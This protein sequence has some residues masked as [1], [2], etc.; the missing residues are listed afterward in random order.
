MGYFQCPRCYG[1]DSFKQR[2]QKF[3]NLG[4]SGVGISNVIQRYCR[5]CSHVKMGYTKTAIDWYLISAAVFFFLTLPLIDTFS[6]SPDAKTLESKNSL[7]TLLNIIGISLAIFFYRVFATLHYPKKMKS[8]FALGKGEPRRIM[9]R[10]KAI[11]ICLLIVVF[12]NL[13]NF[14]SS[15][16]IDTRVKCSIGGVTSYEFG[17]NPKCPAK[18]QKSK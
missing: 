14:G 5:R 1:T 12:F 16:M 9:G 15:K 18:V 7:F 4:D 13:L 8:N 6:E 10:Q 2:E 11:G 17:F 3:R